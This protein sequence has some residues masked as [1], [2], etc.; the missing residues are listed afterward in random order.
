MADLPEAR[1]NTVKYVFKKCGVDYARPF[2]YKEGQRKTAKSV[3]CYMA[4]F[5]CLSTRA[6]HIEL[7][8]DLSAETHLNVLK[9]FISRR[10]RPI[11]L[12]SDNGLNFV[13][14][15]HELNELYKLFKDESIKQKIND[16]MATERVKWHF[17]P[18]RVPHMGGIWEAAIKSAKFHLKRVTKEA[19]LRYDELFTLMVQVEAI[20]N[21]RPLA[22]V[23]NDPS[24]LNALTPGHFMI[25]CPITHSRSPVWNVFQQTDY[26]VGNDSNNWNNI[27]GVVG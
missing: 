8:A 6:V 15:N 20:L 3:K 2:Y 24:D 19:S 21:S 22:P 9:R 4:L 13:G 14:A 12:Y 25:G 11:E 18:P 1:V 23:S 27:R 17:I 7:A 10:G 5:V 16:F 26:H